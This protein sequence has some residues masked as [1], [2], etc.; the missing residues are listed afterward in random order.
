MFQYY[1]VDSASSASTGLIQNIRSKVTDK[2]KTLLSQR[3]SVPPG[4][5]CDDP[6][7]PS[8]RRCTVVCYVSNRTSVHV[9]GW[10]KMTVYF[11]FLDV[12]GV[13]DSLWAKT[14]VI[15]L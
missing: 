10:C 5:P 2:K 12:F 8:C 13:N 11:T 15:Y 6:D 9:G 14:Y 1:N 3:H 4:K 7:S